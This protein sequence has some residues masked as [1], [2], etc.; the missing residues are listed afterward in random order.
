MIKRIINV[1]R[2]MARKQ[3]IAQAP[4]KYDKALLDYLF[5]E[6]KTYFRL[7]SEE[8]DF[9]KDQIINMTDEDFSDFKF[10]VGSF[11]NGELNYLLNCLHNKNSMK[12]TDDAYDFLCTYEVFK[13]RSE[14]LL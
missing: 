3:T 1:F 9:L 11:K 7:S 12:E 8:S 10:S 4:T 14:K 13:D 2:N 5:C 6:E